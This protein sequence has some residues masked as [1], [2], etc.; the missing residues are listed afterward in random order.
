[1][2]LV[3]ILMVKNESAIL[4]RCLEA[5]KDVVDAY[6]ILDTG[7]SDTTFE[8]AEEFLENQIGCVTKEPWKDFGHNRTI[9]FQ[10]AQRISQGA[11]LG[12]EGHIRTSA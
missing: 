9:S 12:S 5:V 7:S 11:V 8:I 10:R 6:C 1:M 3:L 2:K 4:R